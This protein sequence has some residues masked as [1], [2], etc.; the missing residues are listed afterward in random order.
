MNP[1]I[2][3][4]IPTYKPKEYL[5]ECLNSLKNQ[6]LSYDKFEI[7]IILNGCKEPWKLQIQEYINDELKELNV[8]FFQTNNPGVSNARNIGLEKAKGEYIIFIDDDD[9]V[10]PD[11]LKVQLCEAVDDSILYNCMTSFKNGSNQFIGSQIKSYYE[12]LYKKRAFSLLKGRKFLSYVCSSCI[13]IK[14]IQNNRFNNNLKNGED[15][16]FIFQISKNIKKIKLANKKSIYFRRIR[17][18]SAHY[19]T[20]SISYI[21]KNFNLK[22]YY[23][24]KIYL[25]DP[26]KYNMILFLSRYMACLKSLI[27][28]FKSH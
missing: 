25:S 1:N 12:K 3:V 21:L 4:I 9:Y 23:Y 8:H 20:R 17:L 5:W 18:D 27:L 19:Q 10:S 6:T 28:Q 14:I 16:L 2:S 22:I 11:Y 7:I 13:P 24:T 26:F 15:S